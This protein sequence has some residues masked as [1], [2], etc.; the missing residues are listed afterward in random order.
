LNRGR[1]NVGRAKHRQASGHDPVSRQAKMRLERESNKPKKKP[2]EP[3]K[4]SS[5]KELF[6][7]EKS[8]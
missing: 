2:K 3:K 1:G 6:D 5:I 7:K 8:R 4:Y